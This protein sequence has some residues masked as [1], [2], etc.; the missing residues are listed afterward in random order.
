MS[1]VAAHQGEAGGGAADA[2]GLRARLTALRDAATLLA[3]HGV[4]VEAADVEGVLSRA[5]GRLRHGT[6][7][8]VVALAGSTGSGKSSL[9]N[10]LARADV[11]RSGV[12]RPT[13]AIAQAVT[14]GRPA[15]GL[16]AHLEVSRSHHLADG[17]AL[18]GLVLLDLPDFD[19]V[20]SAHRAEADR[21]IRLVDLMVWV[22]D[23]QKYADESLHAGYLRP[24][25]GHAEVML[26]V[27]NKVDTVEG[28]Q[29]TSC[30]ADLRRLL[31]EDGLPAVDPIATSTVTG[32]GVDELRGVLAAEV[33]ARAAAVE[34]IAADL[35]AAARQVRSAAGVA[36]SVDLAAVTRSTAEGLAD[37]AGVGDTAVLVGAQYQRDAGLAVGWPPLRILRRWRRPPLEARRTSSGSA[38]ARSQVSRALRAAGEQVEGAGE[39]W[40]T[41]ASAAVRDRADAVV[42]ALDTQTTR[43][44][45]EVRAAPRW[46]TAA[47][48][49]QQ[50]WLLAL[51]LG[52]V[53]LVGVALAETLLLVDLRQ[54]VPR[55]R[56]IAAP[57]LLAAGGLALGLLTA[58]VGR[59]LAAV[60]ARRRTARAR[61]EL[62]RRVAAVVE[63]EVIDPLETLLA[64]AREASVLLDRAEGRP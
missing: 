48:R 36:G 7:H 5:E 8:T 4:E 56:G 63:A 40:G 12:T 57:T 18:D 58:L 43:G 1:G 49:L 34:R 6:D 11:A 55:W 17:G 50:L 25:A 53:W 19:S 23:P 47:R 3:A 24:L 33:T 44:I 31:A 21:L 46:W 41:A 37:A 38:V 29:A 59:W 16:L 42:E 22:T 52:V 15:E 54:L 27:L 32:A 64:D 28:A 60:G 10:A 61:E 45:Q 62:T 9:L 14:F 30:V 51:V 20:A 35:S 39:G 2:D 13:T 26:V